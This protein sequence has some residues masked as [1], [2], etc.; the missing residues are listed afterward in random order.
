MDITDAVL[1]PILQGDGDTPE[2]PV[3]FGPCHVRIR[4][5][6]ERLFIEERFGGMGDDWNEEVHYTSPALQSV[7]RISLRDGTIRSVY[8]DTSNTT[9]D[10]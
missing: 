4:V 5:L 7:W 9:Y 2:T 1:L 10:K 6:A 3:L 8:F